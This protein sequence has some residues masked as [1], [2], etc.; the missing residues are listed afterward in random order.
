MPVE[1]ITKD[2]L[3]EFKEELLR[4]IKALLSASNSPSQKE[5]LKS[6]EVMDLL[7]IKATALQTLRINR[8]LPYSKLGGTLYYAYADVMN[9][10]N[11]NKRNAQP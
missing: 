2:D 8:Q 9:A 4:D 11:A 7:G 5:W 3:R 6:A 10:L 1:I